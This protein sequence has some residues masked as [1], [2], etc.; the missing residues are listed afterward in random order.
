MDFLNNLAI[1]ISASDLNIPDK[2]GN[3]VLASVLGIVYLIAG[4]VAVIMIIVAGLNMVLSSG[5]A[6]K[7]AKARQTIIYSAVG[8]I[9]VMLAFTL[10]QF[11]LG[12]F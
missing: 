9:V 12:R 7:V 2:T 5:E 3:E 6:A 11:I 1:T 8:L 10:T 4:I